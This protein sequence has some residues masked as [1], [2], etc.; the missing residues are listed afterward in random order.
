Q[1]NGGPVIINNATGVARVN[2]L[3]AY[4]SA[5]P[6]ASLTLTNAGGLLAVGTFSAGGGVKTVNDFLTVAGAVT[7]QAPRPNSCNGGGQS[8]IMFDA[9]GTIFDGLGLPPEVIGFAFQ[10]TF[11]ATTGKVIS[12][13]AMLNG[14]FQDGINNPN[15]GNFELTKNEFDQAFAHE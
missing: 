3:F 7:G 15:A 9:D 6:T 13:G 8:P 10:C 11:S 4:W 1:P 2:T 14:R 12:A 5:L